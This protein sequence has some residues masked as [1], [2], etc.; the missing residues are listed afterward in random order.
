M[1]GR[2]LG[3]G[4]VNVMIEM[5]DA[6][7]ERSEKKWAEGTY[8]EKAAY[9]RQRVWRWLFHVSLESRLAALKKLRG[10]LLVGNS[11]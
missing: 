4:T 5:F 1:A 8:S 9:I 2:K 6:I 10:E 3:L 7:H 11:R